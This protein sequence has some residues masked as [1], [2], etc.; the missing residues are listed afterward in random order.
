[1]EREGMLDSPSYIHGLPKNH[2]EGAG[3]SVPGFT[4]RAQRVE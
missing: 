2:P 4:N 3:E 1:M